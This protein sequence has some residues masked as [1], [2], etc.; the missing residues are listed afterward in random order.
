MMN[1]EHDR[2]TMSGISEELFHTRLLLERTKRLSDIGVLASTVAHELRNPLAAIYLAAANIRRKAKNPILDKHIINIEKKVAESN[3]IINNLFFY[4]RLRPPRYERA[5]IIRII[6]ECVDY[7]LK[8][9]NKDIRLKRVFADTENI[10]INADPTQL[11][12]I[13]CNLLNNA[14]DAVRP[15]DANIEVGAK[16]EQRTVRIYVKDNGC[17]ISKEDLTKVFDPFFTTKAKGTGLGLTVCQQIA[18]MHGGSIHIESEA[19]VGTTV[20]VILPKE[21]RL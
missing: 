14:L 5:G 6:D 20:T 16:N 7:A 18:H 2:N 13:I 12:E 17:G 9:Y 3:Q 21:G 1:H 4:S 8:R 19:L 10:E 15:F 11:R